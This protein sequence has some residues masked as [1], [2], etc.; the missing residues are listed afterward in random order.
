MAFQHAI[1]GESDFVLCR[2]SFEFVIDRE[3][4]H[5]IPQ[6]HFAQPFID[7]ALGTI[8][9]LRNHEMNA[10]SGADIPHLI[11]EAL[12]NLLAVI[13]QGICA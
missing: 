9:E 11:D 12:E 10:R 3:E 4:L 5:S 6:T 1:S 7:F 2:A 8:G 13:F